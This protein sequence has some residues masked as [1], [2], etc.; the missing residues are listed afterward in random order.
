[1]DYDQLLMLALRSGIRSH[2][3]WDM[4]LYEVRAELVAHSWRR[5]EERRAR[6]DAEITAAW[7]VASLSRTK[8]VP[9]LGSLL[10][11]V[12][13]PR[14]LNAAEEMAR[15]ADF[16]QGAAALANLMARTAA[17]STAEE[18]GGS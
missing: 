10:A 6:R 16:E 2:E 14:K 9:S 18:D 1:M 15:H 11:S 7:M 8:R 3:F 13:A 4:T 17:G 12:Q 5:R